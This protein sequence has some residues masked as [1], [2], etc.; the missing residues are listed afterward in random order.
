MIIGVPGHRVARRST[1][2]NIYKIYL[3]YLAM[4]IAD[5]GTVSSRGQ[6]AIPS[7]MRSALGLEEGSRVLF[8]MEGNQV[9]LRKAD[10]ETFS[11]LTEPLRKASKRLQEKDVAT[12]IKRWRRR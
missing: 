3:T 8:L 10:E 2:R 9:L 1:E 11:A 6:I 12:A 5:I 7:Q 4:V